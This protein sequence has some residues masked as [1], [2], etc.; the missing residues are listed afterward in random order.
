MIFLYIGQYRKAGKETQFKSDI[1]END[2]GY[3]V[4]VSPNYL[5]IDKKYKDILKEEPFEI[6][7]NVYFKFKDYNDYSSYRDLIK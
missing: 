5:N 3:F 6:G 4:R 7:Y 1:D 2:S